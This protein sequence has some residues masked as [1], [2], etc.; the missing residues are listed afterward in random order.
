MIAQGSN[1][2]PASIIGH[3]GAISLLNRSLETDRLSHA[4]LFVGPEHV[5]KMTVALHLAKAVNCE[6]PELKPC[7]DCSQCLRI[8]A[9][10]HADVQVLGLSEERRE[11]QGATTRIGIERIRDLQ[12]QA[13]L[14]PYEGKH[15]VFIID[16]AQLLTNEAANSLLKTLEEPPPNVLLLLL[17]TDESSLL[18]T[19]LSRCQRVELRPVPVSELMDTLVQRNSLDESKAQLLAR[20]SA[21]CPGWAISAAE[22]E[23]VLQARIDALDHLISLGQMELE[24]R[25][26]YASELASLF[27]RDRAAVHQ[28]LDVWLTWWRDLLLLK[29]EAGELI[30]NSHR[31]AELE[32]QARWCSLEDTQRFILKLEESRTNL[33][34]NVIPR[35]VLELLMMDLPARV[36]A[37]VAR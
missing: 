9:G 10:Q 26:K 31:T 6:N 16:G 19:I 5:G 37:G 12:K 22:D 33:E 2:R 28:V 14:H 1:F 34:R 29:G 13:S 24:G 15:R 27:F 35:L 20:L 21:G 23:E 25:F 18:P 32:E 7:D 8:A 17:T 30:T 36:S 4:Y 11:G 3:S